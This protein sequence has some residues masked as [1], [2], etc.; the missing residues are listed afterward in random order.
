MLVLYVM[1]T[2]VIESIA[3]L[4]L[5][6]LLHTEFVTHVSSKHVCPFTSCVHTLSL[7]LSRSAVFC[8]HESDVPSETCWLQ[9]ASMMAEK[10]EQFYGFMVVNENILDSVLEGFL[11]LWQ[12]YQFINT[13]ETDGGQELSVYDLS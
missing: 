9:S 4:A 13:H 12:H 5:A 11:P 3:R 2:H 6:S 1:D 10:K 7:L 8:G